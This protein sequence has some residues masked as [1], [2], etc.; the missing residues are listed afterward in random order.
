[1]RGPDS[2]SGPLR[3]G[4]FTLDSAEPTGSPATGVDGGQHEFP[5]PPYAPDLN[6]AEGIWTNLKNGLGNL[7][8]STLDSL[9]GLARS[10]L[11]AMQY[12]PDMLDGFIAEIGLTLE[13][14]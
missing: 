5:L 1:M 12:R 10:R 14:P 9:A 7:A 6:P 13:P 2:P 3:T 4:P 8:P 11:K